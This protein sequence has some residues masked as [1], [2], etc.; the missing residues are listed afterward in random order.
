VSPP[1]VLPQCCFASGCSRRG[2][3]T[4]GSLAR[5][6]HKRRAPPNCTVRGS[7]SILQIGY[8]MY[9]FQVKTRGR[10]CIHTLSRVPQH[11]IRAP[12][13]GGLQC[14]HVSRGSGPRLPAREGS[15][16]AMHLTALDLTP[17]REWAP[18][19]PYVTWLRTSPLH[20]R[21]RRC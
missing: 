1:S 5:R 13:L 7:I 9:K 4:V 8:P 20:A 16:A 3:A 14:C 18:V 2:V 19:P 15:D 17:P 21:G 11:R 10:A 6:L 12:H